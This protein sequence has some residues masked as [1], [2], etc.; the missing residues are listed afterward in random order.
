MD[1]L[2]QSK[3]DRLASEIGAEN[4]PV[5]LEIFLNELQMY[6]DKLSQIEG[7]EQEQYL[8]EISHALKSSAA[9]FGAEALRAYSAEVD[10][11]A[12]SGTSLESES[13]KQQMLSL[14]SETQQR[15]QQLFN[16]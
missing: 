15:Y 2:D 8:K 10:S 11:S 9:S 4:V 5:L 3:I 12:K 6:I 13:N 14:L 1:I 7:Q 16:Q